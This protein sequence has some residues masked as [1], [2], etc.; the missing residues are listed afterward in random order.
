MLLA[1][2]EALVRTGLRLILG[3]AHDIEVVAEAGDGVHAVNIART[4]TVDVAF[5]DVHMPGLDGLA[6]AEELARSSAR[7]RV[8]LLAS[9][10]RDEHLAR[11]LRAGV[12]GFLL[13]DTC[14][15]RLIEAVRAAALGEAVLSPQ[16]TRHLIDSYLAVD[17]SLVESA[18]R[19]AASLTDRE[20]DVLAMLGAGLSNG[21]ISRRLR[22]GEGTV[23]GYVSRLFVKLG[24]T[25]RVQAA[26][27]AYR[28]GLGRSP[29]A[30]R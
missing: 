14:P 12:C 11:A 23:K 13:K 25:N 6:V 10:Y 18:R 27:L 19:R 9:D 28:V 2:D 29:E 24:C 26:V 15:T 7:T 16:V 30:V 20:H 22:L 1:E 17:R 5:V 3:Q 21:Q 4:R 8:V